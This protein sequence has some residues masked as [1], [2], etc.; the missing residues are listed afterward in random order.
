MFR[1]EN[2]RRMNDI[3]HLF[4]ANVVYLTNDVKSEKIHGHKIFEDIVDITCSGDFFEGNLLV[5]F[6]DGSDCILKDQFSLFYLSPKD[7]CQANLFG[8]NLVRD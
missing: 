7:I 2:L 4:N 6:K 8:F 5:R 3:E 1:Y